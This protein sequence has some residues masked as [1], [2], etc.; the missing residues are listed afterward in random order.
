MF[1]TDHQIANALRSGAISIERL[2]AHKKYISIVVPGDSELVNSE[3]IQASSLDL[4]IGKIYVP[5][6]ESASKVSIEFRTGHELKPGETAVVETKECLTLSKNIGAFGFPPA[7]VSRKSILMT[8]PGHVDPGYS[9]HLT[10]TLINMGRKS[11]ILNQD[12]KIATLLI[13]QLKEEV[14]FGYSERKKAPHTKSKETN[15]DKWGALLHQL[16]P[17]FGAFQSRM[18][19]E[20]QSAVDNKSLQFENQITQI[21]RNFSIAQLAI[22]LVT[23]A[24]LALIG[25]FTASAGFVKTNELDS[26]KTKMNGI[27]IQVGASNLKNQV[28]E[29]ERKILLLEGKSNIPVM[30]NE[31]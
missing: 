25:Y 30:A 4:T 14:M 31:N 23:T 9:G 8:N 12:E 17:D 16:S 6:S 2:D 22:P 13:F 24:I 29:L 5:P 19:T 28:S 20:A 7:S 26:L 27:E 18:A 3:F 21:K 15:S 10:F 11:F 1:L